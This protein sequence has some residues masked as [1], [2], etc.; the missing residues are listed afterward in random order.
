MSQSRSPGARF[1]AILDRESLDPLVAIWNTA[2]FLNAWAGV[3]LKSYYFDSAVKLRV[4]TAFQERFPDFFCVPGLWADFGALC[5]PS[6]FGA[7]IY[8]PH[9]G[10]PSARP[11]L[12]SF[13]D[14][15]RL[16]VPDPGRDGLMPRALAE[17]RYFWDHADRGLL[18]RYGYLSGVA[19]SFGPLELAAV[20]LGHGKFFLALATRP[21]AVH[22]L[23]KVTTASVIAW[24]GAHEAVN[25]PLRLLALADHIPG[26]VSRAHY[27]EFFVPYT[28]EVLD[29]F[30]EA[31][32]LYHNEYPIPYP[33]ALAALPIHLFHFG[34]PVA[35]LKSAVGGRIALMGN[36]PPV[37]L[38]LN[39]TAEE[40]RRASVECL[41][42]GAPG[43]G[44]LLSSGGGLAPA[45]PEA[46]LD[47]MA[48]ALREYGRSV[49][50]PESGNHLDSLKHP[51]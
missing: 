17:Y 51:T 16:R 14:I 27:E 22:E 1:R 4:Q 37:Q 28:K 5:E 40:V 15:R 6:A 30:P 3:D 32:V 18:D 44:F 19:A 42:Q 43:G 20:L 36:L 49:E 34:G 24:L 26:Q 33:E 45:T 41:R 21:V 38:L 10:M 47:A 11:V 31:T 25:G 12:A 39:G 9:G 35:P 48:L 7:E 23:L 29:R 8:W 13:D 50:S 2:P 46:N